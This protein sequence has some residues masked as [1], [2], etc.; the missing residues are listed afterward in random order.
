MYY[1]R[2]IKKQLIIYKV[3]FFLLLIGCLLILISK[4]YYYYFFFI[5]VAYLIR[6]VIFPVYIITVNGRSLII[7]RILLGGWLIKNIVNEDNKVI[8]ITNIDTGV[9]ASAW[10]I[11]DGPNFTGDGTDKKKLELYR[12]KYL[13]ESNKEAE[14]KLQLLRMEAN[15]INKI[16]VP[17]TS[18]L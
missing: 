11:E 10:N 6:E 14:I 13:K 7:K 5:V 2:E 17:T 12:I 3:V 16:K 8:D 9:T 4:A 1:N 15:I 18:T